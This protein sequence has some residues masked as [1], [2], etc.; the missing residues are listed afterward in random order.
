MTSGKRQHGSG[1]ILGIFP[2][3]IRGGAEEY[4]LTVLTEAVRAGF[5]AAVAFP[6]RAA[7]AALADEFRAAGVA[8]YPLEVAETENRRAENRRH[9]KR[10]LLTLRLLLHVRP[11]AVHLTLGWPELGLGTIL[12]CALAR[13][14][15]MVV[16]QLVPGVIA[17]GRKKLRLYRW[18]RLSR[19]VWVAVSE[20]NR[21]FLC[22]SF[23][24]SRS[25]VVRIYNGAAAAAVPP[26]E[27]D[28]T[29]ASARAEVRD[30]LGLPPDGRVL[31]TV[32]RLHP[33]KGY[34][35]LVRIARYI[36]D[37][38]PGVYFVWVGDGE[39]RQ[40]LEQIVGA[41]GLVESIRLLGFRRDLTR[42]M[43]AADL[44][45]FPSR[46]EGFPLAL[47]QAMAIGLPIIASDCSSIPE[48]VSDRIHGVLFPAGEVLALYHCVCWA[49]N[50]PNEM[51][52]MAA[53]AKGKVKEFSPE[54]MIA[55]TLT[56]LRELGGGK[57]NSAAM[58]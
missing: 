30:E 50:H 56:V 22:D 1:Q 58:R 23:G 11:D 8:Y 13:T 15:T 44:F 26:S 52:T 32:G 21:R 5:H 18:A 9:L 55:E 47:L 19:Q 34:L 6:K 42:L 24:A 38:F 35:D 31:L 16:F 12:A 7:T 54:R 46:Y 27:E 20:D 25:E 17:F 57:T 48:I 41:T 49:L 33:Q 40:E 29:V 36:V 4:V 43:T 10:L 3:E 2:S 28:A 51:Q 53:K 39:Q 14:P 45:L 37:A